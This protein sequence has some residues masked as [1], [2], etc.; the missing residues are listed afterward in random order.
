MRQL[1]QQLPLDR[2][3]GEPRPGRQPV[4]RGRAEP[5]PPQPA[6]GGQRHIGFGSRG[7]VLPVR[8]VLRTN[9][10]VVDRE[11]DLPIVNRLLIRE[12][13]HHGC[14]G[15]I[16]G[17][18]RTLGE[19]QPPRRQ[20]RLGRLGQRRDGPHL[21]QLL[22]FDRS[23]M[24]RFRLEVR[25]A[26]QVAGGHTQVV[27]RPIGQ[28]DLVRARGGDVLAVHRQQ[29]KIIRQVDGR[30]RGVGQRP[31][32]RLTDRFESISQIGKDALATGPGKRAVRR[33][34]DCGGQHHALAAEAEVVV[35]PLCLLGRQVRVM[36]PYVREAQPQ[37]VECGTQGR[38]QI[39][40]GRGG[41][42]RCPGGDQD[43]VDAAG[44]VQARLQLCERH[45]GVGRQGLG[46]GETELPQPGGRHD[47]D[48]SQ[49]REAANA[50][51]LLTQRAV[52]RYV[53]CLG[54]PQRHAVAHCRLQLI[55]QRLI[56]ND[57]VAVRT[58]ARAQRGILL[59]APERSPSRHLLAAGTGDHQHVGGARHAVGARSFDRRLREQHHANGTF[60]VL[61]K[62]GG[63]GQVCHQ[64]LA[65]E[66][67]DQQKR[68][69]PTQAVERQVPQAA[70]HTVPDQQGT[71]EHGGCR[72]HP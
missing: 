71:G 3:R 41:A 64:L 46:R 62:R 34:F 14:Q 8:V 4:R 58:P 39:G 28:H 43:A 26:N 68:V 63:T 38:C 15:R 25:Q 10:P 40:R 55:G 70:A 50:I 65:K 27:G 67:V 42:G 44:L 18:C 47:L 13:F 6:P 72:R 5:A 24:R 16:V 56:Q 7:V 69:D 9:Q 52:G 19:L 49:P 53:G 36:Q 12:A 51:G 66:P 48:H 29:R 37:I 57:L 1:G 30:D 60:A 31:G 23:A 17:N 59:E 35:D 33:R 20:I 11:R 2:F 54:Q 22:G 45:V 21:Q 32:L 61:R